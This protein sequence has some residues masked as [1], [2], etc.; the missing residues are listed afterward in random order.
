[1]N[2]ER[3]KGMRIVVT[4]LAGSAILHIVYFLCMTAI[5]LAQTYFYKPQFA[6]NVLVLQ[7]EIAFGY[8]VRFPSIGFSLVL[9]A[10]VIWLLLQIRRKKL[11]LE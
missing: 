8:V 6:P 3:G 1:M 7:Q 4:S 11:N 10:V 9:I 2:N 5:G